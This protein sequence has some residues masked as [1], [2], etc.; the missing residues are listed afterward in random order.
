[1]K[2]RI[3]AALMAL[4]LCIGLLP[5]TALAADTPSDS[6]YVTANYD[7]GA[8]KRNITVNVYDENGTI[9]D[10]V[11]IDDAK[12]AAHEITIS[13]TENYINQYDIE[14]VSKVDGNGTF[15][16]ES[17]NK[18]SC[19]FWSMNASEGGNLTVSVQ[20]C[21]E[22]EK[23]DIEGGWIDTDGVIY[24]RVTQA[25]LLKLLHDN[26]VDVD[27]NTKITKQQA[28]KAH[29]VDPYNGV[30]SEWPFD[31]KPAGGNSLQWY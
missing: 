10:T 8:L 21:P 22:F 28:V 12:I 19:S 11:S 13:L 17:V 20:L 6:H 4:C 15:T 29:F 26:G 23:P 30:N 9:V 2:R 7:T 3:I 18:D 24:Y 1:M 27:A 5:A 14:D 31:E 25:A 16:G